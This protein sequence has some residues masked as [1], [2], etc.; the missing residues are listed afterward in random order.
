MKAK[1]FDET[2][3]TIADELKAESIPLP[4]GFEQKLCS[5][6]CIHYHTCTRNPY[7]YGQKGAQ[8]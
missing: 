3:G 4:C 7:R 8:P 2:I 6:K 1:K 5:R